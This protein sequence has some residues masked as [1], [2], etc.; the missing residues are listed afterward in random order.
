M[1]QKY[2]QL[3]WGLPSL[4]SE[5]L[6]ATLLVSSSSAPLG[7]HFVLFNG[8]CNASAV[9]MWDQ[10]SP[11][12]P[13]SHPPP[14]PDVHLQPFSQT[15]PQSQ[16]PPFT[17]VQPHAHLQSPLSILPSSSPSQIRDHGVSFHRS[18]IESDSHISTENQHLKWHM[19]QKQQE[20]LWGLVPAFQ[21]SQE[22]TCPQALTPPLVSQSSHA[23]VPVSVLPGHFHIT[24]EPQDKM[25]LHIPRRLFSHCCLH[26]SRNLESLCKCTETSQ[27]KGRHAHSQLRQLQGQSSKDRAETELSFPG[28]FHETISTKFQLR[29]DMKRNLG[30]ILEKSPEDSPPRVSECYLLKSLRAASETKSSCVC[31]SRNYSGN[32]LLNVSRKDTDQNEMK[33]ILR[34]HLSQKFWQITA[35][36]SPLGVCHSWLAEDNPSPPSGSSQNNMENRNLKNI[37]V[38]GVHPQMTT[39]E[40]SFLDPNT[41]QV[42]EAHIIR[43]HVSQRW[44]LPLKVLESIKSYKLRE[45]KTWPLPQFDFLSSATYISGV[46][47]KS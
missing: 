22:A 45:A 8:I 15:N 29:Q 6:V 30:Y 41:R 14:L 42:L 26:A 32:E 23:Y 24:S 5:S 17:Q 25:E 16:P 21:K 2:T 10:E 27:Q 19:L 43:F 34:L 37:T 4:H 12:L 36:R 20:S 28:S 7:S 11:P 39:P 44:G 13:H 33:T 31:H 46:D 38:G 47:S 18:Q 3:F 9:K 1:Q 40:L 35:G